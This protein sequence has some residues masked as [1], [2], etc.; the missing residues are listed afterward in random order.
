MS[1]ANFCT[2]HL[3]QYINSKPVKDGK[4]YLKKKKKKNYF[5]KA[6]ACESSIQYFLL[7]TIVFIITSPD[8]FI[9]SFSVAI[10]LFT[11]YRRQVVFHT[12]SVSLMVGAL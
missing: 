10:W 3:V 9:V 1:T 11:Q 12:A 8:P 6:E 4:V 7:N 2:S 5:H